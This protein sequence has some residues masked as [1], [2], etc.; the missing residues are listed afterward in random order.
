L[1]R[2]QFS[3]GVDLGGTD[4]KFCIAD[5]DGAVLSRHRVAT[6][7][8]CSGIVDAIV[9]NIRFLLTSSGVGLDQVASIGLGIPGTVDPDRGMIV[10]APNIFAVNVEIVK[11]IREHF[12]IPVY[13]AQDSQAAAWAE[14][15]VGAGRGL[16][17]VATITI[18]T[19]I[20]CGLV[21]DGKI[22]RGSV[23]HT[24][25]E[26]GHQIVEI[27]GGECN[28]G[29]R[30]CLEVYAAGPGIIRA[31]KESISG[32]EDLLGKSIDAVSAK[33]VYELATRGNGQALHVTDK[34][35]KYLGL[36][37]VS[38]VNL[39]S[40]NLITISGGICDAPSDLLFDPLVR[41]VRANAY[42]TISQS[43][44][45]RRSSLGSEAPLIGVT[46]LSKQSTGYAIAKLG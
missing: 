13:L 45:I 41:F 9:A 40:P 14:Q 20:G 23:G 35:V 36:G 29:R 6:P 38:L 27:D 37:L 7:T 22:F 1:R 44:Q 12:D 18:G 46:I 17:S 28:C 30:G 16:A 2:K 34:V 15:V 4:I 33:D 26:L 8:S 42:P 21:I 11:M 19:G 25:G 5:E 10:F 24:A 31:A 32:L 39:V 43:V 3:L